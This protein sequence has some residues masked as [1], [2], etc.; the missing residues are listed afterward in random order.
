MYTAQG[1][2][3]LAQEQTKSIDP[4][5]QISIFPNPTTEYFQLNTYDNV[6]LVRIYNLVGKEVKSF[7]VTPQKKFSVRELKLGL[8]LIQMVNEHGYVLRTVRMKKK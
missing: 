5:V 4:T 8:Y 1:Q 6:E 2:L 7:Q 3:A